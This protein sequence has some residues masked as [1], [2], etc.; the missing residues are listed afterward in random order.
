LILVRA[1]GSICT[2]AREAPVVT[3]VC[4]IAPV[5]S[6]ATAAAAK[7]NFFIDFL[8]PLNATIYKTA[9]IATCSGLNACAVIVD[10][11][12]L[13]QSNFRVLPEFGMMVSTVLP[14]ALSRAS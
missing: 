12:I 4:A 6:K 9:A 7:T 13:T 8:Q 3:V 5:D 10:S 14:R 2:V 11:S 1:S